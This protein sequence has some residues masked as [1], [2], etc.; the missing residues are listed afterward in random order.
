M[1]LH[2]SVTCPDRT[3]EDLQQL[4]RQLERDLNEVPGVTA[5]AKSRAAP[6]GSKASNVVEIGELVVQIISGGSALAS[7]LK[8]YFD[9]EA[10]L[11]M[12]FVLPNGTKVDVDT[13]RATAK[14]LERIAALLGEE[15]SAKS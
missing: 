7:I 12:T 14:E 2:L 13:K 10:R 6:R 1:K 4:V 8:L 11:S 9:R 3:D 15:T 5:H